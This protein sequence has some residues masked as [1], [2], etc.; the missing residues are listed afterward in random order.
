VILEGLTF[1]SEINLVR[2]SVLDYFAHVLIGLDEDHCS[3]ILFRKSGP[4]FQALVISGVGGDYD[5]PFND[6]L[7]G[8][9]SVGMY[10]CHF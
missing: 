1:D 7:E 8:V 9:E 3:S 2:D 4:S 10:E 6:V 5:V